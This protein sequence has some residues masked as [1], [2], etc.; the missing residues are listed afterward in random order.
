MYFVKSTDDG[1]SYSSPSAVWK[2]DPSKFMFTNPLDLDLSTDTKGNVVVAFT[3]YLEDK[4]FHSSNRL[5]MAISK[6]FGNTWSVDSIPGLANYGITKPKTG[7]RSNNQQVVMFL[8]NGY[9]EALSTE[10]L[11]S[12]SVIDTLTDMATANNFYALVKN[13]FLYVA[14]EDNRFGF[15]M[16]EIYYDTMFAKIAPAP[17][18]LIENTNLSGEVGI[19]PNPF[20]NQTNI[21]IQGDIGEK[22]DISIIDMYGRTLRKYVEIPSGTFTLERENL[23]FGT[24]VVRI[25]NKNNHNSKLKIMIVN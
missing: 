16:E 18:S 11:K 19:S 13:D 4:N 8:D 9:V 24:Y 21:N 1:K 5:F 2:V 20:S 12:F 25:T 22:Y 15:G 6:D 14:W 10:D 23:N 3:I 7:I 17:T